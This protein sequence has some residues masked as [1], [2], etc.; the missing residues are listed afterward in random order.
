MV[1][2]APSMLNVGALIL[3]LMFI[4]SILGCYLFNEVY[5]GK[6]INELNNFWNFHNALITLFRA[7]TGEDWFVI[8]FDVSK[9][10]NN[11]TKGK[12]CGSSIF[13]F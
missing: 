7:A 11:C 1:I 13:N 6:V 10:G 5:E 4:Y 9:T 3:L 12:D 2:S 8:M